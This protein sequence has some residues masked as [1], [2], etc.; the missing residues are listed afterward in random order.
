MPKHV[1][2]GLKQ[3]TIQLYQSSL[4]DAANCQQ[5]DGCHWKNLDVTL[6]QFLKPHQTCVKVILYDS[7]FEDETTEKQN[8]ASIKKLLPEVMKMMEGGIQLKL[9]HEKR[10]EPPFPQLFEVI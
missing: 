6:V 3:V 10:S 2:E 7:M 8:H 5:F 1:H 9:E 4:V